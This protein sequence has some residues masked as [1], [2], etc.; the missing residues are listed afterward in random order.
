M[1]KFLFIIPKVLLISIF[2]FCFGNPITLIAQTHGCKV[3]YSFSSRLYYI[4]YPAGGSNAYITT[5]TID[6]TGATGGYRESGS[7]AYGC[8]AEIGGACTV[9]QQYEIHPGPPQN[10]GVRIYKNG[11]YANIDPVNCSIDDFL[12]FILIL[13]AL[14]GFLRIRKFPIFNSANEDNDYHGSI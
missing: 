13:V 11:I 9:Y 4:P 3:A 6:A 12:P 7:V 5:G 8:I 2:L 10:V 14:V 1:K